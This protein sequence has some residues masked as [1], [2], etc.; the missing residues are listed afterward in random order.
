MTHTEADKPRIELLNVDC[1]EYLSNCEDGKFDL[2]LQDTPFGCTKNKWDIKPDFKKMWPEWNRVSK[3]NA[4]MIFFGTQP[5]SSELIFSN[6][7]NFRYDLI[8]YKSL[9]SGFLNAKRMPL[10]NHESILIFY[11][12]LP[13]YNPQ[14]GI[15]IRKKGRATNDR[16]NTNYNSFGTND[17]YHYFD[18]NGTRYPQSVLDFSNGDRTTE[19]DHPTQKPVDLIRYLIKTYSNENDAVFDG[20]AGSGTSAIACY[21]EKRG[22]I[23]CETDKSYFDNSVIRYNEAI[24]EQSLF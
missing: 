17:K 18:D 11:R 14:M 6:A 13:T 19:S 15:G 21:I 9:G 20:Y 1:M 24:K 16:T 22:C 5:F 7:K 8:W 3:D 23:C 10:R 12:K 2:L 4:A